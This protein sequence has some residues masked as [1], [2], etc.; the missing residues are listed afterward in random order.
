MLY[1]EL[2]EYKKSLEGYQS[3]L[4]LLPPNDSE[5]YF[6]LAWSLTRV[7]FKKMG[8]FVSIMEINPLWTRNP[9][10][11]TLTNGEDLHCLLRQNQSSEILAIITCD[12]SVYTTDHPDL[13]VCSFM[14][15]SIGP[16]RV[17]KEPRELSKRQGNSQLC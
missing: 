13:I 10:A 17:K 12:P 16:K 9:L 15:N 2:K 4:S 7:S 11:G 3:I 14:E 6:K 8:I 1:E 5:R